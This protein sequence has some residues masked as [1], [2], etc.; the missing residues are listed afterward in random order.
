MKNLLFTLLA[1]LI[2]VPVINAQSVDQ[3]KPLGTSSDN[4]SEL[5]I[6]KTKKKRSSKQSTG[7]ATYVGN[8]KNVNR[9]EGWSDRY[10]T[11]TKDSDGEYY[12]ILYMEGYVFDEVQGTPFMTGMCFDFT[13]QAGGRDHLPCV[14]LRG[15]NKMIEG[16]TRYNLFGEPYEVIDEVWTRISAIPKEISGEE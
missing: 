1:I 4:Y 6:A 7:K 14:F 12:A 2:A 11:I 3:L 9:G 10:M 15:N 8:W 5:L 16:E 13:R